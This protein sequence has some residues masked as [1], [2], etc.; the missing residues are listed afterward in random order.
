M[1]R[2]GTRV[3]LHRRLLLPMLAAFACGGPLPFLSG[4]DLEG[5]VR[6]S[7]SDWA[8]AG[9]SGTAQL[10]TRPEDPYSV[11]LAYT[12]LDGALYLRVG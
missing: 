9:D 2:A 10:E 11:N 8:F 6:P 4:G 3:L 12:L 5:E 7:P 1:K